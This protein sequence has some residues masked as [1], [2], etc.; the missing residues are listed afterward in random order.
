[1]VFDWQKM[2][3]S[4]GLASTRRFL[5]E[6]PEACYEAPDQDALNATFEDR[7]T[8]LDPRWNLHELYLMFGKRLQPRIMHF[9]STKPWSRNRN[10]A[11]RAAAAWYQ[12][13]LA[14]SPWPDFVEPQSRLD[15]VRADF[16]FFRKRYS[17]HLREALAKML[18]PSLFR[19]LPHR[20]HMPWVPRRSQDVEEMAAALIMEA[21]GRCPPLRPPEA[22]LTHAPWR[23]EA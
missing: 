6:H 5:A 4:D 8:P 22:V 12:S 1:M 10:R 19:R 21:E 9:T 14:D 11:W 17:P 18:P 13:E 20:Q 23:I 16:G 7:W 15:A 2:L 3:A